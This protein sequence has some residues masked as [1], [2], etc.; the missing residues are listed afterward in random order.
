MLNISIFSKRLKSERMNQGLSQKELAEKS[1][2]AAATLSSYEGMDESRKKYPTIDKAT[3]LAKALNVSMDWLCGFS[4]IQRISEKAETDK[5]Y[6][7]LTGYLMMLVELRRFASKAY[8]HT[9][10]DPTS[11][12]TPWENIEVIARMEFDISEIVSFFSSLEKIHSLWEEKIITTEM[13]DEWIEGGLAKYNDYWVD[14]ETNEITE[15]KPI[16]E[17]ELPF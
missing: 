11:M 15:F 14:S 3:A 7:P 5:R 4:D 1:G 16:D 2:I 8:T 9:T 10:G 17:N 13:K 12:G 6:N